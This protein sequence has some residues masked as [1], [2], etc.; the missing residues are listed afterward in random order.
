MLL[1]RILCELKTEGEKVNVVVAFYY[2][3]DCRKSSLKPSLL[4]VYHKPLS[5]GDGVRA[6]SRADMSN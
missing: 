4:P 3:K 1:K 6:T 2:N 5:E